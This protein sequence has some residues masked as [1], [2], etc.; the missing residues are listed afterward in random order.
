[1]ACVVLG[2]D[3][4]IPLAQAQVSARGLP[5]LP[6]VTVPHPIGGIP[7]AVV[8]AKAEAI[9]ERVL[10]ALTENPDASRVAAGGAGPSMEAPGD[11]EEFQTWLM[12][13][14]WGDGLPAIPPTRE[15]VARMLSGTRR[16][17]DDIAA[18][19]VPRLGRASVEAIA[20]NAVMAGARPEHFPVILA[21]VEAVADPA[22]NLQAIQTTT[23]PCSP[24]VI[25]NGPIAPRLG[26]HAGGNVLGQGARANAVIGR[27]LRLTL[28]NVGGARPGK[29]DRAT[30]GHPG[31]YSYCM[32]ENEAA[33]PWEPL[34]VERGFAA[35]E[36]TVTV[37]GSEAPH[38]INDHASTTPANIVTT[39]ASVMATVGSNNIYLGGEPL[40]VL[41]PEHAAT[42]AS[43]GWSKD[44][45]RCQ[46]WE[47]SA[48]PLASFAQENIGRFATIFPE[49]FKDRP[50]GA[51][52]RVAR[53]WRD[54]MV[55]VAGGA[56][57]HSA[58]IPTFGATR[59]VT[60]RITDEQ[61]EG[62]R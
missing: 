61:K 34:S 10:R 54:I 36:S 58:L 13:Q 57:K 8:A 27:A 32:A 1:V 11:I 18:I 53:D 9:V 21:A 23:H 7:A 4:F 25:V 19:L 56:G 46:V 52:A 6:V 29:E 22:F 15:R 2:T 5:S 40:V 37:C 26:I 41:G 20:A 60:R 31:K 47:Q 35:G 62:G 16:R 24:L 12:E 51:V 3:E 14:G 43:S 44:D 33:S 59:S 42:A 28:Q 55:V 48:V 50:P 49:G 30:H 38:N 17:P 45:F 39:V